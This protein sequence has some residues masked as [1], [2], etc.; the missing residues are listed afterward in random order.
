MELINVDIRIKGN[1]QKRLRKS[2][3]FSYNI[4][5]NKKISKLYYKLRK[6]KEKIITNCG[7]LKK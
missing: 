3:L 7:S 2:N 5:H 6:T 1:N 4:P